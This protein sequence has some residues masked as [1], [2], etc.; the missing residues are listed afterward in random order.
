MASAPVRTLCILSCIISLTLG[1]GFTLSGGEHSDYEASVA[2]LEAILQDEVRQLHGWLDRIREIEVLM[3]HVKR[4]KSDVLRR[5]RRNLPDPRL[6]MFVGRVGPPGFPG[7]QGIPG[8]IGLRGHKGEKGPR[9]NP[10]L[11][12]PPGSYGHPGWR[13]PPGFIGHTGDKGD[14]GFQGFNGITGLRGDVGWV[15]ENGQHGHRGPP[16]EYGHVGFLGMPGPPGPRGHVGEIGFIGPPGQIG[17]TGLPGPVGEYGEPGET[18]EWGFEG[19]EGPRGPKG[20]QGERGDVGDLG[21]WGPVGTPG[22]MYDPYAAMLQPAQ[23]LAG[24]PLGTNTSCNTT[25]DGLSNCSW[26][27]GDQ[28]AMAAQTGTKH[29]MPVYRN[30]P[31]GAQ[32]LP[33]EAVPMLGKATYM[34]APPPGPKVAAYY[35]ADMVHDV[36]YYEEEKDILT[37]A[38]YFKMIKEYEQKLAAEAEAKKDATEISVHREENGDIVELTTTHGGLRVTGSKNSDT[39]S[40]SANV[41]ESDDVEEEADDD[42]TESDAEEDE[43]GEGW[44][45]VIAQTTTSSTDVYYEE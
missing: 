24:P 6:G 38:E 13:G 32:V 27:E 26:L 25:D 4:E 12:G 28:H 39:S 45:S 7:P 1:F 40:E 18:G 17:S 34:H 11:R 9:G 22:P 8:K 37:E 36:R 42:T 10:G 30:P 15:G 3:V 21:P 20:H 23:F 41:Q 14:N 16:G 5:R 2:E 33:V 19:P 31:P 43:H 35:P 44:T 29:S